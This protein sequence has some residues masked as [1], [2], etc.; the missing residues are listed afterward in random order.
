MRISGAT[1]TSATACSRRCSSARP[2]RSCP[3]RRRGNWPPRS[4]GRRPRDRE[5]RDDHSHLSRRRGR[6]R[7]R[8]LS[9]A[10]PDRCYCSDDPSSVLPSLIR[11]SYSVFFFLYFFFF[12][13]F[14]LFFFFF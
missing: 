1:R 13:F 8:R 2:G 12:F 10:L 3:R 6:R 4:R 14:F 9:A 11:F 5:W 7:R